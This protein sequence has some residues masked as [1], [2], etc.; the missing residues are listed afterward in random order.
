MHRATCLGTPDRFF[1]HLRRKDYFA[2]ETF[3]VPV[4]PHVAPHVASYHGPDYIS[5]KPLARRR[6]DRRASRLGPAEH[7]PSVCRARPLDTNLTVRHG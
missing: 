6:I 1:R 4:E 7:K 2:R 3:S 5:A